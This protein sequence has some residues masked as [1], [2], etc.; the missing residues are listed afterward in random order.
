[1]K[2]RGPRPKVWRGYRN[3]SRCTCW[4]P[5]SD[6]PV[7][8]LRSGYEQIASQ[9]E[10]CKRAIERERYDNLDD[11]AK[12][13]YGRRVNERNRRNREKRLKAIKQAA[14]EIAKQDR[15]LERQHE[16]IRSLRREI[17]RGHWTGNGIDIV[18]FRMWLLRQYRIH[19]YNLENLSDDIEQDARRVKRWLD[20]YQWNGARGVPI[21]IRSI[22]KD[23][24]INVGMAVDEPRLLEDLYPGESE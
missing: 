18:P 11:E 9:C 23:T 7:Y 2:L 13:E 5:V 20:G 10:Y 12:A 3:C 6:Y 15:K 22:N 17:P 16:K 4:R 8:K 19:E 24:V 14:A 21:P 1:V